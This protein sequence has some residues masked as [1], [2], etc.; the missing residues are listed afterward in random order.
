MPTVASVLSEEMA[1]QGVTVYRLA[2]DTGMP[3]MSASEVVNGRT[4]NPGIFTVAAILA[5]LG[6]TWAWLFKHRPKREEPADPSPIETAPGPAEGEDLTPH[7]PD[8]GGENPPLAPVPA[9]TGDFPGVEE[10]GPNPAGDGFGG[11]AEPIG[12]L[13]GGEINGRHAESIQPDATIS[14]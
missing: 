5:R 3:Y 1:R 4:A 6:K 13:T 12:D 10:A 11:D 14:E 7:R 9:P 2:K 8:V